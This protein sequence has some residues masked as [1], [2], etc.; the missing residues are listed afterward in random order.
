L[1]EKAHQLDPKSPGV[2]INLGNVS[3]EMKDFAGARKYYEE[4][5][6]ADPDGPYAKKQRKLSGN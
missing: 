1:F 3:V 2:L 5:I 6:K 4:A